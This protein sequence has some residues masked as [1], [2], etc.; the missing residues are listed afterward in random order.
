MKMP[1]SEF[2]RSPMAPRRRLRALCRDKS[3]S[4][5]RLDALQVAVLPVRSGSGLSHLP[6][7][8]TI[9]E[10]ANKPLRQW[11][12]VVHLMLS[13]KKEFPVYKFSGRWA[14][15]PMKPHKIRA[16]LIEPMTKLGGI[17]E[18]DETFVGGKAV[19]TNT[20]EGFWSI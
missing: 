14:S 9:F 19:H 4:C 12:K 7:R 11:I 8:G 17:V 6:Y 15:A 1:A 10:N 20:I 16:A 3:V 13:S 5:R 2:G 18:M